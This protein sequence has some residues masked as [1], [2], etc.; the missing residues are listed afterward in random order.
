MLKKVLFIASLSL[1]ACT[2]KPIEW[3]STT[4]DTR[5]SEENNLSLKNAVDNAPFDAVIT[6]NTAQTIDGFG[7]CFNELGWDALQMLSSG[8][9]D[10]ILQDLF[11]PEQGF[12]FTICRMPLGAN[13]YSRKFYSYNETPGDFEMKNFSIEHDTT[14]LL[15]YI[16]EALKYNPKLQV[17]ASPWC[18]PSW[19]KTNKHYACHR[20]TVQ[21]DLPISGEGLEGI[22]QF[23][24]K[25]EYLKAYALYFSKFI[26]AYQSKGINIYAVHV[27]NEPNSC[28]VFPSCIWTASALRDF[29]GK[30]L[31]PQLQNQNPE[32]WLGTMERASVEKIDTVLTDSLAS[33]YVKGVGFQWAGKGA[34]PGVH[35]KYPEVK[36]M[37]TETECGD[38]SNDWA[39]SEH[40]W[41]L[42][43]H[44]LNNGANAYMY[45]NIILDETG[46]SQW[47]WKQNSMISVDSKTKK[48]KFNPEFYLIKHLSHFVK[49]GSK[50]LITEGMEDLLAFSNPDGTTVVLVYNQSK[51]QRNLKIR[52]GE[53]S[54]KVE[55]K[56]K[57][58]N[59][60]RINKLD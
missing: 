30:Y 28:Q 52:V 46:K 22:N 37:Q 20:D 1:L 14:A 17:W 54:F 8:A 4:N 16:K 49:P 42:I 33:K 25:P 13:D 47:G 6:G 59:T 39:A 44:Y 10:S 50:R 3:I 58:F 15:P 12:N 38:G 18:P 40:T 60:F 56:P 2:Q 11:I 51:N 21:N 43:L 27:Q 31:G 57:S 53:K 24:M 35:Q 32:I 5:W 23:I 9:R 34:I 41:Q 7:G 55:L 48:A 36:L 45:W 29:I 26:E 19:M